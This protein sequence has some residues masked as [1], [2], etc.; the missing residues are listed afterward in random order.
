[1]AATVA[2]STVSV[3]ELARA[4][5]AAARRLAAVAVGDE[6]RGAAG[7]RGRAGGPDRRRSS[8]PTRCDLDAGRASGLSAALMDRLALDVARVRAIADGARAIAALPDPVGEV[9]D[10]GRLANGLDVPQGSSPAR[11]DR[12]G[13]RGAAERDDRRRCAVPE[14]RQRGA[15]ARLVVV[16]R[17]PTRCWRGS[18]ARPPRAPACPLGAL[19]LVAGGGREELTELAQL[20]GHRRPDHPA[21]RRGPEEGDQRRRARPG[22]LRGRGQLPRLRGRERRSR[23]GGADHRQREGPAA[24]RRATR[25]RRCSC[26][27]PSRR[28]SCPRAL[29]A[30]R[31]RGVELRGDERVRAIDASV[32]VASES[33]WAEEFLALILAVRV[34]DSYD[35]RDRPRQRATAPGTPRRS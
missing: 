6:G 10:G 16:R 22:D 12:R 7:D 13:L 28:S 17:T 35:G 23:D 1:M 9:V 30:L 26:T 18:R 5:K 33:D 27:P 19:A 3:T 15:A 24:G 32:G 4:A 31:E 34:V 14:V 21:W 25:P 29:E 20:E 8:R 2:S 11:R